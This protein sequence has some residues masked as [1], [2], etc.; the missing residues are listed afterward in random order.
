[1]PDFI[2]VQSTNMEAHM[3]ET[4]SRSL[5][6]GDV[7]YIDLKATIEPAVFQENM[8]RIVKDFNDIEGIEVVDSFAISEPWLSKFVDQKVRALHYLD[9][10]DGMIDIADGLSAKFQDSY[11]LNLKT[12]FKAHRSFPAELFAHIERKAETYLTTAISNTA[13]R[14]Y[15]TVLLTDERY[16]KQ[17]H[18]LLQRATSD[19]HKQWAQLKENPSHE[20]KFNIANITADSP[21]F[22]SLAKE[23]PIHKACDEH[24]WTIIA[25]LE[26]NSDAALS[27]F[28][29]ERVECKVQ[30]YNSG[31]ASITDSKLQSQ[32]SELLASYIQKELVPNSI[33]KARTQHLILSR[34][35]KKN[36]S[37]LE[38][39][40]AA[41]DPTLPTLLPAL[42]KFLSK[43]AIPL[44]SIPSLSAHKAAMQADML[45]RIQKPSTP[46]PVAFL[47]LIVALFAKYYDGVVYA[48]GKFAPRMM[49]QLRERVGE[50]GYARLEGWKEGAK[51]GRLSGE[52][53]VGMGGM[54]G[55]VREEREEREDG[56]EGVGEKEEEKGK[57]GSEV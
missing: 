24:F 31:L 49:K 37:R 11:D 45:R 12:T 15:G 38:S 33:A 34:K 43:Q 36:I 26:T 21:F 54:V 18:N 27:T 48:T 25:S 20:L 16:V 46:A 30:L 32:L 42:S 52:D 5:V 23:K 53:R 57:E 40:I 19:A 44:P 9:P 7:A 2:R 13:Y 8:G 47:T 56:G 14:Q 51:G 3:I 55:G 1:M 29:L 41:A 17:Q 4:F 10:E 22:T 6:S 28:W 50:E 39:T 35:S